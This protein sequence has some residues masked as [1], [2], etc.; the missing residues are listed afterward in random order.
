MTSTL[1]SALEVRGIPAAPDRL[2]AEAEA[3]IEPFDKP[4]EA[5]TLLS[6]RGAKGKAIRQVNVHYHVVI[7][8]GKR[9]AAERALQTHH[10][11][12]S[13]HE[14]IRQSV[15]VNTTWEIEELA[16]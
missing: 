10:M 7:P 16:D 3:V 5:Q 12:C 15:R 9:E 4:A 11:A 8:A 2:R 14:T 1:A 6:T 13:M